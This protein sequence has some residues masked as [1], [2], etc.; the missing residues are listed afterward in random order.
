[1]RSSKLKILQSLGFFGLDRIYTDTS[2]D[3]D[4]N[5]VKMCDQSAIKLLTSTSKTLSIIII[6]LNVLLIYPL[7]A[8]VF[9]NEIQLAIPV[10][11]PFTDLKTKSGIL[12]NLANQLFIAFVGTTGN[13]GIEIT[14]CILK[15]N[16]WVSIVVIC[17]SIDI[18]TEYLEHPHGNGENIER[19]IDL[20][21]RN[22]LIQIQDYDR[23]VDVF[24]IIIQN[25][26]FILT[27]L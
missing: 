27:F 5:Y 15:N 3:S 26:L 7:Y 20:T 9:Q 17:Y 14:T 6:S 22:I 11:L 16:V 18:L 13:I 8:F 19:S 21:F 2:M 4:L 12:L 10:F 25:L 23:Y 24:Q 1:M